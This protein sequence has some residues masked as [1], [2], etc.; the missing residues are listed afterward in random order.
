MNHHARHPMET[1]ESN[2]NFKT[3]FHER[4]LEMDR[5]PISFRCSIVLP[6]TRVDT[7]SRGRFG[8]F[9][10]GIDRMPVTDASMPATKILR[11]GSIPRIYTSLRMLQIEL[12]NILDVRHRPIEIKRLCTSLSCGL[13]QTPSVPTYLRRC[14]FCSFLPQLFRT[15]ER[16]R[17]RSLLHPSNHFLS[18]FFAIEFQRGIS[19][20]NER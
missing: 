18:A 10:C 5:R 8:K 13:S 11:S 2:R 3:T 15:L 12:R 20:R 14:Q 19:M 16:L 17:I 6:P 1:E 7:N 4:S 9:S